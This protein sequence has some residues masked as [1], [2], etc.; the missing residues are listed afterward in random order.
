MTAPNSI[1]NTAEKWTAY[2]PPSIVAA[3]ST[4]SRPSGPCTQ[5]GDPIPCDGYLNIGTTLAEIGGSF[6]DVAK[7][8]IYV[9][10][11]DSEKMPLLGEGVSGQ[12]RSWASIRTNRSPC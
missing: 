5:P 4:P 6:D 3:A 10:D 7:L 12:R 8:A 11:W 9:V 2:S 1:K